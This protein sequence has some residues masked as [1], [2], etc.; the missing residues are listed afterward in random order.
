MIASGGIDDFVKIWGPNGDVP[1]K[2]DLQKRQIEMDSVNERR[3]APSSGSSET[4]FRTINLFSLM[5][6]LMASRTR[7]EDE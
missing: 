4:G 1:S 5:R 7:E 6:F 3:N 2:E